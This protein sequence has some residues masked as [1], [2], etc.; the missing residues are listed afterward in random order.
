MNARV[1]NSTSNTY[2]LWGNIGGWLVAFFLTKKAL[3]DRDKRLDAMDQWKQEHEKNHPNIH[4]GLRMHAETRE[5]ME[6]ILDL[7][8]KNNLTRETDFRHL[9]ERIDRLL[10]KK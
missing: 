8:Q 9:N 6:H 10:E 5:M 3:T 1:D 7:L 4:E 2:T